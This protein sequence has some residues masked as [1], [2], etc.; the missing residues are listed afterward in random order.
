[1]PAELTPDET[2]SIRAAAASARRTLIQLAGQGRCANLAGALS[3]VDI[4]A[5][6]YFQCLYVDTETPELADRD[7]IVLSKAPALA[8]QYAVMAERGFFPA[9]DLLKPSGPLAPGRDGRFT[10]LDAQ[11]TLPGLGLATGL[12]MALAA[13]LGEH[14]FH[15]Y[16]VMGDGELQ[17]GAV[18]EAAMLAGHQAI[19]NLTLI[20]DRNGLQA[21]GRVDERLSLNPLPDK[22]QA[23][24]WNTLLV[25]GHNVRSLAFTIARARECL[26]MPTVVIANT[27]RGKG[28]APAENREEWQDRVP[29]EEE[30]ARALK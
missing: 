7:R 23:F 17:S 21:S 5:V 24:G 13:R 8:A 16:V 4:L 1:M 15:A 6:L 11:P 19:D 2:E 9:E 26:E 3:V 10:F 25:D 14:P 12:G 28:F 29:S 18:W 30:V 27:T 20:V 22:F